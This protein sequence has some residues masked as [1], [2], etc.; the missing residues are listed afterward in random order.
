MSD[1][2]RAIATIETSRQTH[3]EWRDYLSRYPEHNPGAVGDADYHERAV[4]ESMHAALPASLTDEFTR[5]HDDPHAD[6]AGFLARMTA[7]GW[8]PVSA[9]TDRP[10]PARVAPRPV[11]EAAIAE[12][13]SG[14]ADVRRR[15]SERDASTSNEESA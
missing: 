5:T 4:T 2:D 11:A 14:L 15:L 1:L 9:I 3:V 13:R 10:A 6:A 7:N 8:R 12:I